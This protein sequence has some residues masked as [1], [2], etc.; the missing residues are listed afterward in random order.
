MA[1]GLLVGRFQPF[2]LGHLSVVK[3]LRA[4][5][6]R[7]AL[8]L[9][10]GSAQE[11]HTS[12]NPFTAGERLEMIER[13]VAAEKLDGVTAVPIPDIH[14]HSVW[15]AHVASLVPPFRRVYTNNPLTRLLFEEARYPVEAAPM[16][17]R[18]KW[19]GATVRA[20]MRTGHA[21]KRY[22][23]EPV[24][25]YLV[26]IDAEGRLQALAARDAG[27]LPDPTP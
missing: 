27:N 16:F 22:L 10:I 26:S 9:G 24:A 6:P 12:D 3:H 21:W 8:I 1:R 13:T 25:S 7:D 23:P 17:E 2:H 20:A 15:V 18:A 14:R 19:Q 4:K 11:S 5:R